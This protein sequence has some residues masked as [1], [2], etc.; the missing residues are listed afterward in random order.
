MTNADRKQRL[1]SSGYQPVVEQGVAMPFEVGAIIGGKYQV[2]KL[3]GTGGMGFV[4]SATHVELGEKV[5]LKFLRTESLANQELVGR[6]AREARAAVKIK[7]EYVARVFDVGTLPDGSPFIVMEYLEGKDLY[8]TVR[9]HGPLSTLLAVEYVMQA[10]EALAVAH[11]NGIVHRDIKPENLFLA[12]RG[13]GMDVIKVL[14]FGIS[15][16]ALTGSLYEINVPLVRTMMPMGSPVYMSPEQIRASTD[17]D[18]RTDIW[19]LGCVLF[20]LLTGNPAFDAPSLTQLSAV[21]LEDDPALLRSLVPNAPPDLE[22]IISKCLA[23][24]PAKRFQ[25]VGEL[26]IALFPFAPRRARIS[27]ER[28]CYV[29]K[30]AGIYDRDLELPSMHPPSLSGTA[31]REDD[32]AESTPRTEQPTTLPAAE[33]NSSVRT[34]A[35]PKWGIAIAAVCLLGLAGGYVFWSRRDAIMSQPGWSPDKSQS[36]AMRP[37]VLAPA[38]PA[39][40]QTP[41]PASE[42]AA[43]F[44]VPGTTPAPKAAAPAPPAPRVKGQSAAPNAVPGKG[45]AAAKAT[46]DPGSHE[47]DP[48]F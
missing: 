24:D 18:M 4:V 2:N 3:I 26:A 15:K 7:S 40:P 1:P 27:A 11:A 10:C 30:A 47:P 5:A 44:Q 21:I 46:A 8:V 20:E 36:A 38:T 45:K 43:A 35:R 41:A 14:D 16:V 42:A 25:N 12:H 9:D 23:K 39:T 31:E 13:Q 17:I 33:E 29:L 32:P 48:G 19:S 37:A 34:A 22:K 6:F 28:C